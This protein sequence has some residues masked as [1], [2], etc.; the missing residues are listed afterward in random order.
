MRGGERGGHRGGRPHSGRG[1]GGRPQQE[2]RLPPPDATGAEATYLEGKKETRAPMVVHL[3]D[4][5][6]LRGVIEYYDRDMIKI[7]RGEGPNLFIRKR[8]IRYMYAENESAPSPR[9]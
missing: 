4:G 8:I 3:V 2:R 9:S 7:H 5:E 1:D 6:I